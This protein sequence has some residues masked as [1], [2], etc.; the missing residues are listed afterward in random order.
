V[1]HFCSRG[2]FFL[3]QEVHRAVQILHW[4]T[5]I[6]YFFRFP[7]LKAS[8]FISQDYFARLKGL[9]VFRL[10]D[11]RYRFFI[12]KDTLILIVIVQA[13][14]NSRVIRNIFHLLIQQGCQIDYKRPLH[15]NYNGYPRVIP[16][17]AV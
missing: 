5:A 17:V 15:K 7:A 13:E 12:G 1:I 16:E 8:E 9:L 11:S 14:S 3:V 4:Y 6:A 10:Q 2:N